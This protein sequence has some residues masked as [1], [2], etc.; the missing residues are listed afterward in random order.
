LRRQLTEAWAEVKTLREQ[1]QL[2]RTENKALRFTTA[3]QGRSLSL[4]SPETHPAAPS[5]NC[6]YWLFSDVRRHEKSWHLHWQRLQ[7][8]L[9]GLGTMPASE[10]TPIVWAR[11]LAARRAEE[12]RGGGTPCD[13]TLNTE[14]ARLKA[15]LSWAVESRMIPFSPLQA[16]KRIKTRDR[17]ETTLSPADIDQLLVEAESLRDQRLAEGDDDGLR[18]RMLQAAALLWHD[19]MMRP[20][21]ARHLR[22]SRIQQNGDYRIPREHTKTDAGERTVTLTGRTMEAIDAIPVHGDSDYVF[23]NPRT[24]KLLSYHTFRRWFRWTC[25]TSRMDAKAAPRD[26]RIT[27]HMLRHSGATTA[28]AAG[29]RPGA[30]STAIGHASLKSTE[31][32]I[33]REG[34]ESAHHVAEKMTEFAALR[35][36]PKKSKRERE[37]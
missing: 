6:V 35:H 22:R 27:P 29:V 8:S 10:V 32:Y 30:L 11:H 33:H 7:P 25:K 28:D 13:G 18:S 1:N 37:K 17:R 16:A 14:L 3:G 36:R 9:R 26:K 15:M 31:R 19:T 24:G 5:V 20:K 4:L 2:L 21:E 34:I 23:V 12:Q